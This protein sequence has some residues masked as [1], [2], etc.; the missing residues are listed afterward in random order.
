MF[1]HPWI[2]FAAPENVLPNDYLQRIRALALR[3]KMKRF[4]LDNHIELDTKL[5]RDDLKRV[6]SVV[7]SASQQSDLVD[8]IKNLEVLVM[9][10]MKKLAGECIL[11]FVALL[12]C[13]AVCVT[14]C[15]YKI[16]RE[17]YHRVY[18]L[19]LLH[20][21]LFFLSLFSLSLIVTLPLPILPPPPF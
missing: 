13:L 14:V 2:N 4:F 16:F 1:D 17:S 21:S 19:L 18:Y 3:Q 7:I 20:H 8:N 11:D 15:C 12:E 9:D 10:K 6:L 5:R